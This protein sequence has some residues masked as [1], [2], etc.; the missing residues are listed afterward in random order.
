MLIL[1]RLFCGMEWVSKFWG[2]VSEKL[3]RLY[4]VLQQLSA[5][6]VYLSYSYVKRMTG[7]CHRLIYYIII[8]LYV[9][10]QMLSLTS[11]G[12]YFN[13]EYPDNF[14]CKFASKLPFCMCRLRIYVYIFDVNNMFIKIYIHSVLFYNTTTLVL[15]NLVASLHT[16]FF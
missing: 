6:L 4:S 1:H 9:L 13:L 10:D 3:N 7:Y 11:T 5:R 8:I 12:S 16:Q 14:I 2:Y 15:N